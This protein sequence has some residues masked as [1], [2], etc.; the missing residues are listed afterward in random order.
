MSTNNQVGQSSRAN[1][2][3]D[4]IRNTATALHDSSHSFHPHPSNHPFIPVLARLPQTEPNHIN[5]H[6]HKTPGIEGHPKHHPGRR[7]YSP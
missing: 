4:Y 7:I 5:T 2:P 1:M 3:P 6:K